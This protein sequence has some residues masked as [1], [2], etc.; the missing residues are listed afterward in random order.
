[1]PH[2]D[3][4][5]QEIH[6]QAA[7]MIYSSN[8]IEGVGMNVEATLQICMGEFK[9][10]GLCDMFKMYRLRNEGITSQEKEVIQHAQA[11]EHLVDQTIRL[12]RKWSTELIRETH[13]ILCRG[14]QDGS[15]DEQ[16]EGYRTDHRVARW[17]YRNDPTGIVRTTHLL[18]HW[19]VSEYMERLVV[20]LN[21]AIDH[22]IE[23]QMDPYT[24][25]AQ[26]HHRFMA[27]CP[28]VDENGRMARLLLNV[29]LL[30]FAGHLANFGGIDASKEKYLRIVVAG[31]VKFHEEDTNIE[32]KAF[33]GHRKFAKFLMRNS[34]PGLEVLESWAIN[35]GSFSP[36][37]ADA[38]I[39]HLEAK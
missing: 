13:R 21:A 30:K 5:W 29:I 38:A 25:A 26:V 35:D 24:L 32:T 19:L 14:F 15:E 20:D 17:M 37:W 33:T 36:G 39:P 34:R 18:C 11:W 16:V 27:I 1:M 4:L 9:Y 2:V 12:N 22:D 8:Y 7:M 23:N 6:F 10:A 28:F 3:K 31:R